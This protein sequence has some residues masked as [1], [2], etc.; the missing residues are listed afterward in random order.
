[1]KNFPKKSPP[2]PAP[3]LL[4]FPPSVGGVKEI[5]TYFDLFDYDLGLLKKSLGG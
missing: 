5:K 3:K 4:L 1:M 2:I